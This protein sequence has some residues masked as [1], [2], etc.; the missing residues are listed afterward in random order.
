MNWVGRALMI[1]LL[2]VAGLPAAAVMAQDKGDRETLR[3]EVVRRRAA[4]MDKLGPN[5]L[6][7]IFSGEVKN[8]ERDVDYLYRQDSNLYYLTGITQPDVTLV[9]LPGNSSAREILFIPDRDLSKETWFGKNL[10][11]EEADQISGIS[12]IHSTAQFDSFLE[13]TL[14][15]RHFGPRRYARSTE[16]ETFFSALDRGEAQTYLILENGPGLRGQ[17]NREWKLANR[18]RENFLGIQVRDVSKWL[19]GLRLV[20]SPYEISLLRRATTVTNHALNEAIKAINSGVKEFEIGA[21]IEYVFRK[22]NTSGY[23]Y[24]PIVGSGANAT[25]LHYSPRDVA[26]KN[27]DLALMDV[28]AE[29]KQYSADVTRT[30][31]V[32][33]KFTSAQ[34][35]I[36]SIV[37]QAADAALTKVR[38]GSRISDVHERAVDLLKEGLLRVGLITDKDSEQYRLWFPHGVSHWLGMNVHDVGDRDEPFRPGMVLTVEPGIYIR[39]AALDNLRKD[40]EQHKFLTAIEPALKKYKDIG[41]RIED[42]VVVTDTSYELL[43]NG[44]PR[45]ITEI[46]ALMA[47]RGKPSTRP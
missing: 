47:N 38:V 7:V 12:V 6:C 21:L 28:G 25:V 13:A 42:D 36:Y 35:E 32:N 3:Q 8:Y 40:P 23:G 34:A 14:S 9:L 18:I 5:A 22:S 27:G 39:E 17:A 4:L 24:P 31:P 33:G 20:K 19:A 29:Y 2:T 11:R 16:F 41:I 46:E 43:S 1:L 26:M 45:T 10:T 44:S 37:L 15:R 30:V